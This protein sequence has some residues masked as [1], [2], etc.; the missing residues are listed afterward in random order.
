M[1]H[2]A[3]D[4]FDWFFSHVSTFPPERTID[5][6]DLLTVKLHYLLRTVAVRYYLENTKFAI[7]SVGYK[8]AQVFA[9]QNL[10]SWL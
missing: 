3:I 7:D 2:E 6:T 8:P 5:M 1:N 10:S 4:S 9:I